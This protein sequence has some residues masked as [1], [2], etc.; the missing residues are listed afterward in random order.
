M[1]GPPEPAPAPDTV[2]TM[3]GELR[4]L[5]LRAGELERQVFR[6]EVLE[7]TRRLRIAE[8]EGRLARLDPSGTIW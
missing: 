1:N 8:L 2:A 6:L 5:R 4:D 3:T 7:L